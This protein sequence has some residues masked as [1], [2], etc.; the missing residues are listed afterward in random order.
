[1]RYQDIET[2][3]ILTTEALQAEYSRRKAAGETEAETFSDYLENCTGNHGTLRAFRVE[4]SNLN[5]PEYGIATASGLADNRR[6]ELQ[7][8]A[9]N[10]GFI[11]LLI[12]D[13]DG[14]EIYFDDEAE[15]ENVFPGFL[16]AIFEAI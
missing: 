15:A 12:E 11:D 9:E 6:F 1:M 2:G 13:G 3:E 4:I 8:S 16:D 5:K 10:Y 7:F 14:D